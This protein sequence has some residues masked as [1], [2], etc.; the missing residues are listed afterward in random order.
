MEDQKEPKT[1]ILCGWVIDWNTNTSYKA[2]SHTEIVLKMVLGGKMS[3]V[4]KKMLPEHILSILP[5]FLFQQEAEEV[6]FVDY[7]LGKMVFIK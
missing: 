1:S 6:P 4:R 2:I 3:V 5:P 7:I